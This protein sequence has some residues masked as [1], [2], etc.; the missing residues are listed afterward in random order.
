MQNLENYFELFIYVEHNSYQIY[1]G[2]HSIIILP[3]CWTICLLYYKYQFN[4]INTLVIT[5]VM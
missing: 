3:G 2:D 5:I 4:N 1:L